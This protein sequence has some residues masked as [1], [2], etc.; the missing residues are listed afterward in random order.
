MKNL[1][2]KKSGIDP[3]IEKLLA[4]VRLVEEARKDELLESRIR[5]SRAELAALSFLQNNGPS[6]LEDIIP[7]AP[8]IIDYVLESLKAKGLIDEEDGYWKVKRKKYYSR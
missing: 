2:V 8:K 5:M 4:E 1:H 6:S 3:A 7:Y